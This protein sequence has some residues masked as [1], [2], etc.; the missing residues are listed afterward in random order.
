M[1]MNHNKL[2]AATAAGALALGAAACGSDSRSGGSRGSGSGGSVTGAGATFPQPVYQEWAAQ[3][4]DKNSS[5]VNY[6]CVGSGDGI[7]QFTAG[8][9]DFGATDS[10]MKDEG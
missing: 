7:A 3:F 9:V 10:A 1:R 6:Q 4:K 8:T 5:T 2:L